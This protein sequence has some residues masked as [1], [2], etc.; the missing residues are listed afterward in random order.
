MAPKREMAASRAQDK[1]PTEPSQPD[2]T[3]A[4]RKARYDTALFNSVEEYQRYK[5]KF[6]QRKVIPGRS[7]NFYQLQYFGFEGLFGRMG[8]LPVMTILELI[9]PTL[10]MAFYLRV[11]YGLGGPIISTVRGVEIQ[12]DSKSIYRIFDITPIGLKVYESK[13]W[14]TVLGFK[15]RE[16]I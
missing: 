4:R 3:E 14:P 6:T 12:L 16:T 7:I 1:H 5:Q 2:Q 15:P 13:A 10:V 9:F 11:T 8:W